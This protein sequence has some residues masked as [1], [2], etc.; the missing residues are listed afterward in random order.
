M[1]LF[2]EKGLYNYLFPWASKSPDLNL[3]EGVW[4]L[5]KARINRRIPRPNTNP[6]MREAIEAEWANITEHDLEQL[7]ATMPARVQA[8]LSAQGGHTKY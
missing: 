2:K 6:L 7:L 3:M 4:R 1:K 5:L 8:V